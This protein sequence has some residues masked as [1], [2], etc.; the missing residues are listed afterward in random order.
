MSKT[1][2][3]H[4]NW[5]HWNVSLWIN[6]DEELFRAARAAISRHRG[7][8]DA[9]GAAAYSLLAMLPEKTPDGAPYTVTSVRAAMVGM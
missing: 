3:G 4:R 1:Y 7:K 5:N 2:N 9:K 6:N 8:Q